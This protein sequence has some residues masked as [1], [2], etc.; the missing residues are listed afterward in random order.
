MYLRSK[1]DRLDKAHKKAK[2][3]AVNGKTT[4]RDF[5]DGLEE[6]KY[7]VVSGTSH[8]TTL[9]SVQKVTSIEGL[10]EEKKADLAFGS[11]CTHTTSE[12]RAL[13]PTSG[14][15]IPVSD[16]HEVCRLFHI[17]RAPVCP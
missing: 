4:R 5:I 15:I 17:C 11:F 2:K 9:G 6:G 10:L 8:S 12:V 3:Y 7:Q 16:A 13:S 14:D 1:I